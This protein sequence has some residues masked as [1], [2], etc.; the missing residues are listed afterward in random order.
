[1][2]LLVTV[3][4]DT[5]AVE[6]LGTETVDEFRSILGREYG[7]GDDFILACRND[8]FLPHDRRTLSSFE[9][10]TDMTVMSIQVKKAAKGGEQKQ[11][12]L[13]AQ[14]RVQRPVVS[15]LLNEPEKPMLLPETLNSRGRPPAMKN[16]AQTQ[17]GEVPKGKVRDRNGWGSYCGV[18]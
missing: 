13:S 15:R 12:D 14:L 1:M 17:A 10:L 9:L 8:C 18:A 5:L 3:G 2:W 4:S 7:F 6:V 16:G 11:R